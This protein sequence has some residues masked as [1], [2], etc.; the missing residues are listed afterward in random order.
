MFWIFVIYFTIAYI[1]YAFSLTIMYNPSKLKMFGLS[2][3][4]LPIL[5]WLIYKDLTNQIK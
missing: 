1:S 5:I 2:I 3:I 4:W